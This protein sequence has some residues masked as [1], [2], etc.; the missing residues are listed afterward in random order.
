M[1]CENRLSVKF[2]VADGP[3]LHTANLSD[4]RVRPLSNFERK[5]DGR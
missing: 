4:L 1:K 5:Q 2:H 3:Y